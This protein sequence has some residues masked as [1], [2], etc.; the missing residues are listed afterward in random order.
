MIRYFFNPEHDYALANN[1]ANFVAP[2]S[3]VEFAAD[4]ADFMAQSIF[5]GGKHKLK[6]V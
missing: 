5:S 2:R 4:C 1:D 3:A 6:I